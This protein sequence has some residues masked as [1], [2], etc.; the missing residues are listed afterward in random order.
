[1]GLP[2]GSATP[3][4]DIALAKKPWHSFIT[5]HPVGFWF[6]FWG[7]FAERC[8]YYGMRAILAIYMADQLGLGKANAA[9]YM[10]FFIAAC[11]FLPLLGGYIADN[12]LG[13]YRTIVF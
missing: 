7:E 5:D 6:I 11:Y 12:Y 9:T 3:T 1:M 13:K 10:S 8:S 2:N 4:P